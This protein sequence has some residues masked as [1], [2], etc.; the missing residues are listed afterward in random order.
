MQGLMPEEYTLLENLMA[1]FRSV[2][3][4]VVAEAFTLFDERA[5][6]HDRDTPFWHRYP[7]GNVSYAQMCYETAARAVA[8][9]TEAAEPEASV[10]DDRILDLINWATMWLAWRRMHQR[11]AYQEGPVRVVEP[12]AAQTEAVQRK[13]LASILK[14]T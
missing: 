8:L 7:F 2:R 4:A 12:E 3:S 13:P 11:Q 6:Q 9:L 5:K 10:L 1:E 14:R